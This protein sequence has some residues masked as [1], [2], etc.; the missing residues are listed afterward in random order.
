MTINQF[1][2]EA[3]IFPNGDPAAGVAIT[4]VARAGST[5]VS[6]FSDAAGAVP[7]ANPISTDA[8]GNLFFYAQIGEYDLLVGD[9]RVPISIDQPTG[10]V[11]AGVAVFGQKGVVSVATGSTPYRIPF[12]ATIAGVSLAVMTAPTGSD[13]IIDPKV[14]GLS[15]FSPSARPRIVAGTTDAAEVIPDIVTAIAA[16]D[17][18]TVDIVQVG[19]TTPGSGIGV[20]IRYLPT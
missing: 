12:A 5:P 9:A 3:I 7:A 19:S 1:G 17:R 4:V 14:N 2:P 6:I 15:M 20:S 8:Y 16:G 13:I 18:L 10:V 11:G